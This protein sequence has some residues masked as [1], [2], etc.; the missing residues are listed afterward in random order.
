MKL[1]L[2]PIFL[3]QKL[4]FQ[5][6]ISKAKHRRNVSMAGTKYFDETAVQPRD[7]IPVNTMWKSHNRTLSPEHHVEITQ[8]HT[9][10]RALV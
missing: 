3:I 8:S 1:D 7:H 4:L 9:F 2:D 6:T 5:G 10:A